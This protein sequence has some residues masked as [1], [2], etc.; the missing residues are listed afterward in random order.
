MWQKLL[1]PFAIFTYLW[2]LLVILTGLRVIKTK[3]S[4]HKSL[5]LVAFILATIHAGVMIYLSYF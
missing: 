5:A 4:V 3:V 2:F 1:I